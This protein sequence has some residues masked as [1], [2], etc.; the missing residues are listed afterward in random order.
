MEKCKDVAKKMK[1]RNGRK[2]RCSIPEEN[3]SKLDSTGRAGKDVC[4]TE[5]ILQEFKQNTENQGNMQ[6]T[7]GSCTEGLQKPAF[8]ERTRLQNKQLLKERT[9]KIPPSLFLP[10]EMAWPY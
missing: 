6:E 4:K 9:Q 3:R 7:Q 8:K 5:R 1:R 10:A 2:L